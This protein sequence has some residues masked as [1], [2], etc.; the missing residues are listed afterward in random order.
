M[1]LDA[2]R[3]SQKD[4]LIQCILDQSE[5]DLPTEEPHMDDSYTD[6]VAGDEIRSVTTRSVKLIKDVCTR[7]NSTLF[8]L[9]L[10]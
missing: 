8:M 3:K 9:H 1:L 4:P 2:L 5:P 6:T 7:W 10:A